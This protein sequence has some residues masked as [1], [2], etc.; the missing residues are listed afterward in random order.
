MLKD[1]IR[2]NRTYRRFDASHKIELDDLKYMVD[3]ARLGSSGANLQPLKYYLSASDEINDTIFET[4]R[5]AGG[6]KDWNGPEL[7]E[8]PSGYIVMVHDTSISKQPYWDHGIA[9]QSILLTATE[10][11]LGGCMFASF[12]R[13][14]AQKLK[15]DEKYN[16]LMV[17]A[18]GKPIEDVVLVDLP[19]DGKTAYY[20]DEKK[21][22]Y[23]PKRSLE[24]IIL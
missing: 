2:K 18:I 4:L 9:A 11:G 15:L 21:T 19:E 8:R 16:I 22:H 17:I 7:E 13:S 10:K 6:L 24:E 1:L 12:D 23:V 14:L 3:A 5:W 20:R